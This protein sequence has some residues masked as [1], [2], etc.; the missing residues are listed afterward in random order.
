M[1]I[2]GVDVKEVNLKSSDLSLLTIRPL[3]DIVLPSVEPCL[4]R[5][6]SRI[7]PTAFETV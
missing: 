3:I 6:L 5:G 4:P 2:F 7:P 1:R